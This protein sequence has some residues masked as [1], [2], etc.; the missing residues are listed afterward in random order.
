[1]KKTVKINIGGVIFHLDE[2]AYEI[3][4]NYL[5]AVNQRFVSSEEGKEIIADIEH[6]IAEIL[7]SK[8]T[9]Q[10][11]VISIED[12]NEVIEIMG[13]PEEFEGEEESSNNKSYHYDDS[14]KRLYRDLDNRILGGVCAGIAN[15]L[16]IDPLIIRVIFI[17]LMFAF[18]IIA[19][20][21]IV[22]WALLPAAYTTAQKLDMRGEKLNIS[23][24]EKNVRKEYESVK[25]NLKNF[26]NSK[27]YDRTRNF[28]ESIIYG[29]GAFIKFIFKFIVAVFGLALVVFGVGFL[30][31][32]TGTM[33]IGESFMP[34][35]NIFINDHVIFSDMIQSIVGPNTIW[36]MTLCSILVVFIPLVAI[37]YGGFKL[38]L[39][40]RPNDRS[41]AGIGFAVWILSLITLVIIVG[42]QVKHFS[43]SVN[44]EERIV[45]EEP[46]NKT[47]YLKAHE[48]NSIATSRFY[49]F[50]GEF[51][52]M[53]D[54]NDEK[55]LFAFPE[56]DII[57]GS[58]DHV[59]VE[60]RK[61]GRGSDRREALRN[62]EVIEYNVVQQDSIIL[63]DAVYSLIDKNNWRFPEV[64]VTVR[65]PEGYIL[66]LD[67]S[68]EEQLD[69]I[70]RKD[71]YRNDEMMNKYW[72]M[73]EE[74]LE[75]YY[76]VTYDD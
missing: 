44:E 40:L 22:L 1:M 55:Q 29:I 56:I 64:D 39:G 32:L 24:I 19:I 18:G 50:D 21:Y 61:K 41:I 15:Y 26:K 31:G 65:V 13:R 59:S 42:V 48:D 16:N 54:E 14:S 51:Q 63:F 33:I 4:Q 30:I 66:Y 25:D 36:I 10:K 27:D 49:I 74:G 11:Q 17:L 34:W 23:D 62:A 75:R 72:I 35:N 2:D 53:Y 46:A 60:I 7:Q 52:I 6:R 70:K 8:L 20:I 9:E 68:I 67:E 45:I 43:I 58:S 12:I 3:L 28:F 69:Y 38:L 5:S 73:Q 76:K 71:Y 47:L 37:I 57:R